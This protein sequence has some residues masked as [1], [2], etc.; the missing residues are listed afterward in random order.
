MIEFTVPGKPVGKGRPRFRRVGAFVKTYTP[1][2]TVSWEG[3]VA[4]AA[5]KVRGDLVPTDSPVSLAVEVE[6]IPPK[7]WSN[8]KRQSAV[9]GLHWPAKKPDL[10]NIVKAIGDALNGVIWVD[11]VQVVRLEASKRYGSADQTRVRISEVR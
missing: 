5:M 1:E 6:V 3:L 2:E 8:K 7:S 10:D 9:I 11:D 4:M